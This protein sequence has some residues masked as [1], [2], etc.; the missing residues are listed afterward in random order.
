M[1]PPPFVNN[2][3]EQGE[4][5]LPLAMPPVEGEAPA[6][7]LEDFTLRRGHLDPHGPRGAARATNCSSPAWWR[8]ACRWPARCS[9]STAST[10]RAGRCMPRRRRSPTCPSMAS[11]SRSSSACSGPPAP[12]SIP[13]L[14]QGTISL[15]EARRV[16]VEEV[17]MTEANAEQ[18]LQRYTFRAPGQATSYFYGYQRLL[19][20][21]AST[22]V[23]LGQPL[24]P[25]ALPRLRAGPGRPAAR[26]AREAGAGRVHSG[27]TEARSERQTVGAAS[28]ATAGHRSRFKNRG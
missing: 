6:R 4:F 25:P 9:P 20:L 24:R 18:E 12:S 8:T 23:A 14:Q 10:W 7:R 13:G 26:P 16:L 27:G 11:S 21:R 3:G 1:K 15:D 17:V 22:E 5:V 19:D 28:A 2:Q